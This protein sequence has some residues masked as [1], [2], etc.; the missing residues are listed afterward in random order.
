MS[1]KLYS[2]AIPSQTNDLT[3]GSPDDNTNPHSLELLIIT[4]E[5]DQEF[6]KNLLFLHK[7]PKTCFRVLYR[8]DT[9]QVSPSRA[10]YNEACGPRLYFILS[11]WGCNH[12]ASSPPWE[13]GG[14]VRPGLGFTNHKAR[15]TLYT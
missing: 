6:R 3:L 10:L 11:Y 9:A 2:V 4:F 14:V 1:K 12:P 15:D 5:I 13:R 8:G 7:T